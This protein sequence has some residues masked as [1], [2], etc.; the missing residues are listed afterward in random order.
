MS[1]LVSFW[2]SNNPCI[3]IYVRFFF[4]RKKGTLTVDS[5][6]YRLV[7]KYLVIGSSNPA[8]VDEDEFFGVRR[9]LLPKEDF[10]C[11]SG[12]SSGY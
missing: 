1:A 6:L 7:K 9:D 3:E 2:A 4:L 5:L 11:V 12:I 8:K 10:L